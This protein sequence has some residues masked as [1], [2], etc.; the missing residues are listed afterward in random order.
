MYLKSLISRS[1]IVCSLLCLKSEDCTAFNFQ[2][3][4]ETCQLGLKGKSI[5]ALSASDISTPIY[6]KPGPVDWIKII[7]F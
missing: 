2:K 7:I 5:P 4:T 3:E 6:T 1:S